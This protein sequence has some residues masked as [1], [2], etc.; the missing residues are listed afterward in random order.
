MVN[1]NDFVR[2]FDLFWD[3]ALKFGRAVVEVLEWLVDT[4]EK[5]LKRVDLNHETILLLEWRNIG[6]VH[7]INLNV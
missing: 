2:F 4:L 5:C 1:E 3:S 6:N 7:E